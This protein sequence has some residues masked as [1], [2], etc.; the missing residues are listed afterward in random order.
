M[1]NRNFFGAQIVHIP[2]LKELK[3]RYPEATITLFSK[4]PLS[5][6]LLDLK[7]A[8]N[9][10][11]ETSKLQT[12]QRYLKENPDLTVNLRKKSLFIT[13]FISLFNFQTKIGFNN[14]LSKLFFTVTK[15]HNK[16]IYR[17][18]NYLTLLDSKLHYSDYEAS[19]KICFLPGAGGDFKMWP[20][21][22]YIKLAEFC[23]KNY[24]EYTI[25]FI[26]GKKEEKFINEI[27]KKFKLVCN[28]PIYEL[29][30]NIC[31]ASLVVANDCGPSHIAQIN[32]IKTIILV[33]DEYNDADEVINEW[34]NKTPDI[35]YIKGKNQQTIQTI[36][37][38]TVQSK[39]QKLMQ[40][41]N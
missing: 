14:F 33:S 19:K 24:P 34:I 30:E 29:F 41:M 35:D 31:R 3:S 32:N 40:K 21:E 11:L 36:S 18:Q 16:N 9:L 1:Q 17:A 20:L 22:N 2:L 26:L 13:F 28:L 39:V 7:V 8:D 10:I 25:E 38:T 15:P 5:Q 27:P 23:A 37:L 4:T 6:I 12:F